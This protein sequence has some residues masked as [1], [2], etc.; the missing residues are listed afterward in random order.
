VR[1]LFDGSRLC[2]NQ[3]SWELGMKDD[4]I[5]KALRDHEE[6]EEEEEND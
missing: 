1:F 6:E 5:I 4:D 3:T 2:D